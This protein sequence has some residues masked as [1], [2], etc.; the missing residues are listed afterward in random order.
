MFKYS[1]NTI[2]VAFFEY[3]M[4]ILHSSN[5]SHRSNQLKI[6]KN[7]RKRELPAFPLNLTKAFINYLNL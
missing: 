4:N 1:Q 5:I 7:P 2:K 6:H 3:I